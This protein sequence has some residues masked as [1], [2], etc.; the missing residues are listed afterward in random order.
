LLFSA[1]I[2]E[3]LNAVPQFLKGKSIMK[4]RL[5]CCTAILIMT[6]IFTACGT[7]PATPASPAAT[8][9][10]AVVSTPTLAETLPPSQTPDPCVLPQLEVEVQNVHRHMREFDDAAKLASNIPR[11]E[12]SDSIANLQRIR[13]NAQDEK[14]AGC[15]TALQTVQIE[16]MELVIETLIAFMGG[17][18]Q[19]TLDQVIVLARNKHDEYILELARLLGLTAVA[20]TPA[21]VPSQ[22]PTP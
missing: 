18:D 5:L 12:L 22:T 2:E 14:V 9:T 6:M 17:T 10:Q 1:T 19:Q 11:E 13:R 7:P 3:R 15:L 20:A 4:K 21:A 8:A 16:H